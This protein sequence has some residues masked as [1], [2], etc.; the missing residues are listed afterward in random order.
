[1]P[2]QRKAR[3]AKWVNINRISSLRNL[4]R[5][6]ASYSSPEHQCQDEYY[7]SPDRYPRPAE[8]SSYSF[9]LDANQPV[10]EMLKKCLKYGGD[11]YAW[12]F[13][14]QYSFLSD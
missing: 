2:D 4:L 9:L 1:M 8:E 10:N 7:T 5:P 11:R 14:C 13:E 3:D 12:S 6:C